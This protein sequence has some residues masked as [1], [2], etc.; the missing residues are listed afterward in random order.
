MPKE[1]HVVCSCGQIIKFSEIEFDEFDCG[2]MGRLYCP[3]CDAILLPT[4]RRKDQ[5]IKNV[6]VEVEDKGKV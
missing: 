1:I 4:H 6:T 3:K 5:S 2:M